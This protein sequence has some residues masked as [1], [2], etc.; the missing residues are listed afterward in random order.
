MVSDL[1][2]GF[3]KRVDK[4]ETKV[5]MKFHILRFISYMRLLNGSDDELG[6]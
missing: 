2:L 5:N 6:V 3:L 4:P 1:E